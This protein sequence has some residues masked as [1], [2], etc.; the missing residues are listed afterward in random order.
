MSAYAANGSL[1]VRV[2]DGL[3][4][5]GMY[6]PDGSTF[7]TGSTGSGRHH[8]SGALSVTS[9]ETPGILYGMH[10]PDGSMYVSSTISNNGAQRIT[11]VSGSL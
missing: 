6:H 4:Y 10:A 11:F 7:V 2:V 8:A 5:V 9:A 3:T 1:N